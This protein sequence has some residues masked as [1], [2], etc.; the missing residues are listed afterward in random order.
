MVEMYMLPPHNQQVGLG[1]LEGARSLMEKSP[2][3]SAHHNG[4]LQQM[5][6]L[7]VVR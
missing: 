1:F 3:H 7:Q 4:F 2:A 6:V 5:H